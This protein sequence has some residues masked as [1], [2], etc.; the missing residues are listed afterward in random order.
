MQYSD[1]IRTQIKKSKGKTE[2]KL[3]GT[4]R[5]SGCRP[6]TGP[7]PPPILSTDASHKHHGPKE[8][9]KRWFCTCQ[10]CWYVTRSNARGADYSGLGIV[11]PVQLAVTIGL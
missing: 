8:K 11:Q 10:G 9:R 5:A 4:I 6:K 1:R 2:V 7:H 3:L